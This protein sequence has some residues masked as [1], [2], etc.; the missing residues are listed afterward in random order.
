MFVHLA[1]F[2]NYLQREN[3]GFIGIEFSVSDL[4]RKCCLLGKIRV[5]SS[6]LKRDAVIQKSLKIC[7]HF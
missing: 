1:L 7:S 4:Y 3:V 2:A 5:A 6:G